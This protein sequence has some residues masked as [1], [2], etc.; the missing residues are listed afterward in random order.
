[1]AT[2]TIV[3]AVDQVQVTRTAAPRTDRQTLGEVRLGAGGERRGLLMSH[4]HPSELVLSAN[5]VRDPVERVNGDSVHPRDPPLD[6]SVNE[7]VGNRF[8]AHH[9][10]PRLW[11]TNTGLNDS[12][13]CR[14]SIS[15]SLSYSAVGDQDRHRQALRATDVSLPVYENSLV[16]R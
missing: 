16:A 2:V 4:V 12:S 6:E 13:V 15:L 7:H 9:A 11:S 1:S 10:P 3:Q 5:G 14:F 8:L